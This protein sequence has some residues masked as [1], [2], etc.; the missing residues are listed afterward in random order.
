MVISETGRGEDSSAEHFQANSV[1]CAGVCWS[2]LYVHT[3]GMS[4]AKATFITRVSSVWHVV[5]RRVASLFDRSARAREVIREW[6]GREEK[7][8]YYRANFGR[9][10]VLGEMVM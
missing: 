2:A 4:T 6:R 10:C 5:A 3:A 9:G 8:C 7:T 1:N